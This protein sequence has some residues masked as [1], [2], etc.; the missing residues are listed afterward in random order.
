MT[1]TGL[2][3]SNHTAAVFTD[4]IDWNKSCLKAFVFTKPRVILTLSDVEITN[5]DL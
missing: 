3:D 2:E 1:G 4:R 5:K